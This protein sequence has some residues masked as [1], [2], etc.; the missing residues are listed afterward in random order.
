MKIRSLLVTAALLACSVAQAQSLPVQPEYSGVL[1]FTAPLV[2]KDGQLTTFEAK[3]RTKAKTGRSCRIFGKVWA[4]PETAQSNQRVL[5]IEQG[6]V[7]IACE[8][9]PARLILGDFVHSPMDSAWAPLQSSTCLV[10]GT[11]SSC[12]V[13]GTKVDVGTYGGWST[14]HVVTSSSFN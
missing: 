4:T 12:S 9:E 3:V 8:G 5:V 11:R 7:N 10:S 6:S 13:Y 2:L 14:W 1:Q